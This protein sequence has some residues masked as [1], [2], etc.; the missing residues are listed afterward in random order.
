MTSVLV[1]ERWMSLL[2]LLVV[3]VAA[4]AAS[5][6]AASVPFAFVFAVVQWPQEMD[7]VDGIR[8]R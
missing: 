2:F 5:I 8:V 7:Q 6:F 4:A 1:W 3:A